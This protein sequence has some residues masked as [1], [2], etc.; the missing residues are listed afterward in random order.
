VNDSFDE[1]KELLTQASS[2]LKTFALRRIKDVVAK[3]LPRK[4]EIKLMCP[5][6]PLQS[7]VTKR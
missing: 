5:L 2:L 6:A 3:D 1:D 7:W 4:V